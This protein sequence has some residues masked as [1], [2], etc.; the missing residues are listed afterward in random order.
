MKLRKISIFFLCLALGI[1]SCKKDDEGDIP[2]VPERDRDEQQIADKDSIVAYLE[3][4]YYN[5]SEF[6]GSNPNPSA[7][8]LIITKLEAGE[9]VP[10]GHRLLS[11]DYITKELTFADT[12]YEIFYI[13]LNENVSDD[14]ISPS[15]ADNVLVTYEGFRLDHDVFDSAATPVEFDLTTLI[16]GWRKVLPEFKVAEDF[17]ENG[18][19]TVDFLNHGVGVMFV[20]SGLAY[21]SSGTSGIPAYTP[22][23]FKFDLLQAYEND[24]DNDLVPS[25]LEDYNTLDGEFTLNSSS[26]AHD[27]DDTDGDTFPD[28][29]D[30]DDD[31]DGVP[32]RNEDIDKDGDPTNDIGKN[33]IPKYLD[34]EETESNGL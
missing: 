6:D 2:V 13:D 21:F 8:D 34:P 27:G 3:S 4:H 18:D 5:A 22:I 33:G 31:G 25:Y 23:I 15:F 30:A 32:T 11:Q 14:A 17:V 26:E 29:F 9:T 19:G 10:D 16:P 28:Y 1:L 20:P 12:D 24:H 7:K